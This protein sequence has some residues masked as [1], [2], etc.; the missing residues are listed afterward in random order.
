MS[1]REKSEFYFGNTENKPQIAHA[2]TLFGGDLTFVSVRIY[3]NGRTWTRTKDLGLI[4][5]T[6]L[7]LFTVTTG[8]KNKGKSPENPMFPVRNDSI[9]IYHFHSF[10]I[11]KT[12]I[13]G[14]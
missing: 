9:I 14:K 7:G 8:L 13:F 6:L 2:A 5:R 11:V 4:R 3:T 10:S 12:H 1:L